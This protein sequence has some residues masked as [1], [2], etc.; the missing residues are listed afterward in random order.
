MSDLAANGGGFMPPAP[1]SP[2]PSSITSSS[3]ATTTLPRTRAHPL[4][5]GS[6]KETTFIQH[7]DR[8]ILQVSRRYA[9]KFST[10]D[11]DNAPETVKGYARFS[12]AARDMERLVDVVWVSSTPSLQTPYLL[13]LALLV[14]S[15]LPAFTPSP[16]VTFQLLNKLDLAFASLLQGKDA[17]SGEVLPGFEM[18][19]GLST[20]DKVRIK[21]LIE[22]TRLVVVEVMTN[23]TEPD[24][25]EETEDDDD[26]DDDTMD[27]F[28]R[29]DEGGGRWETEIVRVY[30]RTLVELG[31]SLGGESA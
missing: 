26:H 7:V 19:R 23:E 6:A 12:E 11:D 9:K 13:S 27:D 16:R 17:D 20:T 10:S 8:G 30:D 14:A 28:D 4:T 29:P 2:P 5:P 1:P 24:S 18:S 15:Y 21:S 3:L 25:E 31:E 22:R